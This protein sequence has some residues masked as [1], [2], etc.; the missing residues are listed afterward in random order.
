MAL[1]RTALDNFYANVKPY[2]EE[3]VGHDFKEHPMKFAEF[4]NVKSTDTGWID[5][6]TVSGFTLFQSKP[7][8]VDAA[9]DDMIQGPTARATVVTYAKQH[10]VSQEAIEDKEGNKIVAARMPLMLRAGRATQEV[11]GHDVLNSAQTSVTTPDG[12]ALVSASHSTLNGTT[13]DNIIT[14]A[15]SI[16][17]VEEA[18]LA[19]EG[20]VDDRGIPVFQKAAKIVIPNA[21]RFTTAQV[22]DSTMETASPSSNYYSNEINA[23][24]REGLAVVASQ[25]MTSDVD[26]FLLSDDHMLD[27]YWR[28][29]PENWSEVDYVKSGVRIG[30]RFR[31]ATAAWDWRGIVG[32]NV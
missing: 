26:W 32:A 31:C 24:S 14:T 21:L 3:I 20:Q 30:S 17:G 23:V 9:S 16:A 22:L 28:I 11:L 12:V 29:T 2:L 7:E 13:G 6:A 10:L 18:I 5:G 27:W 25:F 4:L 15:M 19:L 8:L 1:N